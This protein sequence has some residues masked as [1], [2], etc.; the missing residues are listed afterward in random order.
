MLNYQQIINKNFIHNDIIKNLLDSKK[1]PVSFYPCI[2][3]SRDSGSGGRDIAQN[4]A[5]KLK[6]KYLDRNKLMR[7]IVK[8]A[9]LDPDLVAKALTEETESPWQSLINSIL[10]IKTL[11]D[12][13]FI[14]TLVSSILEAVTKE[15]VVI[16]GR[17][18]NFILP[19]ETTLRVRI[20]AP[21]KVLIKYAMKFGGLNRLMARQRIDNYMKSRHDFI[22]KYFSRDLTKAHYYDLVLNTEF[23]TIDDCVD[24]IEK[25]FKKKFKKA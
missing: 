11:N 4:I 14:K 10:G 1:L 3:V 8:K 20:T 15:P 18:S 12:M 6:I 5:Q 19:K 25:T 7:M 21:R 17:G 13:I 22:Y 9:G 23:L 16:L 24:I 2:T